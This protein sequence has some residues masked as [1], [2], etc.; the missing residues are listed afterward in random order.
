MIQKTES[1]VSSLPFF[2]GPYGN[3]QALAALRTVIA[4]EKHLDQSFG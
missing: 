2:G 1:P 3:L 4:K